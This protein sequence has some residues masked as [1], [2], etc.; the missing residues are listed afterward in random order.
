MSYD[1]YFASGNYDGQTFGY[2]S[3]KGEPE[4]SPTISTITVAGVC[5]DKRLQ[6][7]HTFQ[8]G[9]F[10]YDHPYPPMPINSSSVTAMWQVAQAV[11]P[12]IFSSNRLPFNDQERARLVHPNRP[13]SK[14]N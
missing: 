10:L 12:R 8:A 13:N 2:Q 6:Q 4:C 9:H 14:L 1:T 3:F 7:Q 5:E 11:T